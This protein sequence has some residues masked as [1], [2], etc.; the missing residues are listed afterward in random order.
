[1][2]HTYA[3]NPVH[4]VFSTKERRKLIPKGSQTRLW[5]FMAGV[6]K[7]QKIFVHEIGG[8]DDHLHM[9]IEVPLTISFSDAMKEI[10]TSS[11]RWM[12]REFA[13]QPGFVLFG[14]SASNLDTVIRY[15]RTQEAH[16]KKMTFEQEFIALLKKH[17]VAYD[18]RYVFG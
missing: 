15:I 13:W 5:A 12:G 1:M 16:H 4:V 17:R 8:M 10:K 3:H 9:L 6:C 7:N 14:V 11:S 18:P 2:S